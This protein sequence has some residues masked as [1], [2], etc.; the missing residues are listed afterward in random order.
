MAAAASGPVNIVEA[1]ADKSGSEPINDVLKEV[2]GD[3]VTVRFPP[4]TYRLDPIRLSGSGW[5]LVG[6]GAT[7]V[8]PSSANRDYLGLEGSNWTFDGFTIDLSADGAAPTNYLRGTDWEF[9]NVEFAGQMSDPQYR[10][11][12]DL[13]FPAVTESGATGLVENV[14]AMD[15]SADPGESSNR[16]LT[17]FGPN[18]KGKM[19][20]RGCE[21]SGWA[22][23]TLYAA[24]SAGPVL[25]EDCLFENTNVGVRVGGNTVI[26]NCLWRQDGRVPTQRWT[27]DAN[28]RGVWLNSNGYVPGPIEIT[29]C[30]FVMTG[31]DAVAAITSAH[32][33]DDVTI[34]DTRIAQRY[35]ESA[36]ELPGDGATTIRNVSITGSV[37]KSAI[38]VWQRDGTVVEGCCIEQPGNGVRISGST[39][40]RVAGSTVNV[41]GEP[42][43]F[44]DSEVATEDVSNSGACPAPNGTSPADG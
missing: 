42:L 8:V 3:D 4:G 31:K 24:E 23:N 15:G 43:V 37:T 34:T 7:L 35:D 5:T 39:D 27:G 28:G 12:S 29:G 40:C 32:R 10:G 36:I 19:I 26:R 6:E 38:D 44:V 33:V 11:E 41:G 13:L 30:E 1:G 14:S 17:W 25:I 21:F 9:K 22:N 16:G 20:W 18:N 2:H